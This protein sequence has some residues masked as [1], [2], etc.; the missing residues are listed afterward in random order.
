MY[1]KLDHTN[2]KALRA[3]H[4]SLDKLT[5]VADDSIHSSGD[6]QSDALTVS[7]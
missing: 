2:N 5:S 1:G 7:L 6:K 4:M 3:T